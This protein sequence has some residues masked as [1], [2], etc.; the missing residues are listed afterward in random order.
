MPMF[1]RWYQKLHGS[2]NG[3]T[4]DA[5]SVVRRCYNVIAITTRVKHEQQ[6]ERIRHNH[7]GFRLLSR[8]IRDIW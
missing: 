8:K 7:M 6:D 4:F 3:K 1:L 5:S 2:L